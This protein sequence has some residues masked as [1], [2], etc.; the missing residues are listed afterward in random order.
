MHPHEERHEEG[1]EERHE[2]KDTNT[3]QQHVLDWP[4]MLSR[5]PK[6]RSTSRDVWETKRR[7]PAPRPGDEVIEIGH[8]RRVPTADYDWYDRDGMRVRVREI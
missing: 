3:P 8:H 1:R 6:S 4:T 7:L 5:T 2:P